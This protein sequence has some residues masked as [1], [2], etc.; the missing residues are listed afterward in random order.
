M[1][2]R[3]YGG[4][5]EKIIDWFLRRVSRDTGLRMAE[6]CLAR[7]MRTGRS[8]VTRSQRSVVDL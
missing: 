7:W 6:Y 5:G 8:E 2:A 1:L 4:T 3:E